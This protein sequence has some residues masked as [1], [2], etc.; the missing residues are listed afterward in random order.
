MR[1]TARTVADLLQA[2]F[3]RF[4]D[5]DVTIVALRELA[6]PLQQGGMSTTGGAR[7]FGIWAPGWAVR[8]LDEWPGERWD[9]S[10]PPGQARTARKLV[11]YVV[12]TG[13]ESMVDA[14]LAAYALGGTQA[15][16][17]LLAAAER[18]WNER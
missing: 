7:G 11:T 9:R 17:E 4:E 5:A 13:D 8:I 2:G 14:A 3:E 10:I 16:D 1:F 12:K 6:V 18:R 15:L